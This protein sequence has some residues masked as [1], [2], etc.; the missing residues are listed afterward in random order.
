MTDWLTDSVWH[1]EPDK[2]AD[3]TGEIWVLCMYASF[4]GH[5]IFFFL[6]YLNI[7]HISV[8]DWFYN[9]HPNN[10]YQQVAP[11]DIYG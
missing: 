7:F 9:Y 4:L 5:V 2:L 11:I 10:M 8:V 6:F 1:L 3:N